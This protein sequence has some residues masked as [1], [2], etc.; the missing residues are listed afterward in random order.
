MR[1]MSDAVTRARELLAVATPGPWVADGLGGNIDAPSGLVAEVLSW[2]DADAELIAAAPTL[3]AEL[4]DEVERLWA[5]TTMDDAMVERAARAICP[6][7]SD[8]EGFC[9]YCERH[10]IA[11]ARAALEAALA[12]PPELT[13]GAR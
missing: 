1:A 6:E 10:H 5:L 2:S 11:D 9:P 7:R 3:L 13:G 12:A 8:P 4:A